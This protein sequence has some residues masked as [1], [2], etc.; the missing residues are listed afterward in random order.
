MITDIESNLI[1][2]PSEQRS[3]RQVDI[4]EPMAIIGAYASSESTAQNNTEIDDFI[5]KDKIAE[6]KKLSSGVFWLKDIDLPTTELF[7]TLP[8]TPDGETAVGEA[9]GIAKSGKN[10]NHER[11]WN[12]L[13]ADLTDRKPFNYYPR[14]RVEIRNNKATVFLNPYL[15]TDRIKDLIATEYGLS[16]LPVVRFVADNSTHY[17]FY[18]DN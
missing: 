11:L 15:M 13:P 1:S 3:A 7:F 16:A 12:C 18:A 2:A 9:E 10:Y 6:P 14:G 17:R 5:Y 4:K 8:T